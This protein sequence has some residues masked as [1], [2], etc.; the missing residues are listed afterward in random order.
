MLETV[1][2]A[3]AFLTTD[4]G[5]PLS[6]LERALQTD[7]PFNYPYGSPRADVM[8]TADYWMNAKEKAQGNFLE[9]IIGDPA[10]CRFYLGMSRIDP[11]TAD[12]LR[13]GI[14]AVRLRGVLGSA[15]FLRRQLS[16]SPGQGNCPGWPEER[17]A[18]GRSSPE[19]RLTRASTSS[20]S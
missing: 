6:D 7:R 9:A 8:Y 12:A 18:P 17:S 1:N 2:A 10:L 13:Q 16:D 4:S 15:G 5:F 3:R 19:L 14:A 11:E 20:I